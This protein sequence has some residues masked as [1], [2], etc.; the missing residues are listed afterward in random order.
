M[1]EVTQVNRTFK[2][3]KKALPAI[4]NYP[5]LD[6][7]TVYEN[8]KTGE[9]G[10]KPTYNMQAIFSPGHPDINVIKS[11]AAAVAR[12]KWPGRDINADYK[13]GALTMPWNLGNE[14]IAEKTADAVKAGKTP[15][16]MDHLKD[17]FI[18]K[19]HT[20][21]DKP[22]TLTVLEHGK[23]LT[24]THPI[25]DQASKF[26]SGCEALLVINF[27]AVTYAKRDYVTAYIKQVTSLNEGKR[28]AGGEVESFADYVGKH[29]TEN[30][31]KDE[32]PF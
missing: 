9:K 30:P 32:I 2:S 7:P 13:S 29:T 1:T 31:L 22:P 11:I 18:L 10:D 23:E 16:N 27:S 12:E 6:K 20:G 26:Y 21:A 17:A 19:A 28:L 8:K 14:V 4:L 3:D 25:G 15:Y 24:L 5:K